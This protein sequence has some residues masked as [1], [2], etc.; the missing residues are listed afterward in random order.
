MRNKNLLLTITSI[1]ITLIVIEV[2][3][4]AIGIEKYR[5]IGYPP[6]YLVNDKKLGFDIKKN[7]KEIDFIFKDTQFKIWSNDY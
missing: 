6:H 3:L 5:F 4:R 2:A 7:S 1:M